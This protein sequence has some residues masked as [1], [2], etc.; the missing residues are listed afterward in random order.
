MI[1]SSQSNQAKP[2]QESR[3]AMPFKPPS[4]QPKLFQGLHG[5]H[6]Q[7]LSQSLT[8]RLSIPSKEKTPPLQIHIVRRNQSIFL[9]LLHPPPPR[10]TET[11][12][13]EE[14]ER[15]STQPIK[16]PH[17]S[18]LCNVWLS[19]P[20]GNAETLLQ[21]TALRTA[22]KVAIN[23]ASAHASAAASPPLLLSRI[24]TR[25]RRRGKKRGWIGYE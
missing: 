20:D 21:P 13:D 5:A 1:L 3:Q 4:P 23:P 2:S 8:E 15:T 10:L 6:H 9:F 19:T 22:A 24:A 12:T 18:T 7:D 17:S 16:S 11:E 14:E 25:W